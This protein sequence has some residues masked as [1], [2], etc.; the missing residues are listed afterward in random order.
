M[1]NF[2]FFTDIPT[3]GATTDE[4]P[5]IAPVIL[6]NAGVF[7]GGVSMA[8]IIS[9][10]EKRTAAPTPE[11]ALPAMKTGDD[12]ATAETTEP[13]SKTKRAAMNVHFA[14]YRE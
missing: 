11:I 9:A 10:P 5:N 2:N 7:S 13:I 14:E 1:L 4:I 12:D 8:I 6:W 3:N